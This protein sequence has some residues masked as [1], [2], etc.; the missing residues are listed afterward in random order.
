MAHNELVADPARSVKILA[1]G[2]NEARAT[3]MF[4]EGG[5]VTILHWDASATSTEGYPKVDYVI[6]CAN[7]TDSTS[8]IEHPVEVIETTTNGARSMLE[9]ARH[10]GA[11]VLVLST[12]EVYGQYKSEDPIAED[13]GGF[14]DA[15]SVRNSYPEAKRLDEALVAAYASEF[16]VSATVARLAQTFGPGVAY[17]DRRV[18]AEF[19]RDCV[20]GKDITLLTTGEKRN[21]YLSTG[22]AATGLLTVLTKGEPGRAYNVANDDTICSIRE[23]AEQVADRFGAGC[24]RVEVK[25]DTEA[26]KRFRKGDLL[27]LDT[28]AARS[29]GWS[30]KIGLMDMYSRMTD[31]WKCDGKGC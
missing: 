20:E 14:L 27:R 19:A 4:G 18:F 25:V 30:P 29:L 17:D 24:T 31:Q 28:T 12:M 3:S 23:M 16:G 11:R 7:M 22:D 10:V 2:R 6:H 13:Q 21:M 26:A 1:L 15:M 8:F 5:D 9:Y